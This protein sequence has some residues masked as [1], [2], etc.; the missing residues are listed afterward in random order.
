[1][2]SQGTN[3][4]TCHWLVPLCLME[5]KVGSTPW[6]QALSGKSRGYRR[7]GNHSLELLGLQMCAWGSQHHSHKAGHGGCGAVA[8]C[9][10]TCVGM[11]KG[12][13]PTWS[14]LGS[15]ATRHMTGAS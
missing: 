6:Q 8:G 15:K 4:D 5:S 1:M 14:Q 12:G 13:H 2:E 10:V 7:P 11:F 9:V 3:H